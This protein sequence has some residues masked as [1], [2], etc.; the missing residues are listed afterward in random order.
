MRANLLTPPPART[1]RSR[2][3]DWL[4][5][6]G[7][8]AMSIIP[9]LGGAARVANLAAGG[10][11][12]PD[13]ARFLAAPAVVLVHIFSALPFCILGALQLAPG[14][15]RRYPGWHRLAGRALMVCGLLSAISGLWMTVA[16]A[17]PAELQGGLLYVVRLAVGGGMAAS[18]ALGWAAILR[19]DVTRHR[20]W[21]LRAYALGQGAGTQALIMLPVAL[22]AGQVIGLPRDILMS[23]AWL[24][25]LAVAEWALRRRRGVGPAGRGIG[26]PGRASG[27]LPSLGGPA[28]TSE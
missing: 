5:P 17:I 10:P 9:A 14:L 27:S 26:R 20:A 1:D 19:G 15:R 23:L 3:A 21:L 25:N 28:E 13:T 8:I 24:I 11:A 18:I 6:A 7:L 2:R 22:A 16:Y 12:T 4:V